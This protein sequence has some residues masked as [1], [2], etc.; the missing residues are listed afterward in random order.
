[1]KPPD[2]A[3]SGHAALT[4]FGRGVEHLLDAAWAGRPGFGPIDRFD[5]GG[6]RVRVAAVLPGLDTTATDLR[7]ELVAAITAAAERAGLTAD[8]RAATALILALHA[9]PQSA[10]AR[11]GRRHSA[12]A[13]ATA[14]ATD[15]GL[16]AAI[17]TYTSACVAASTAVASA[18]AL[19]SRAA[20]GDVGAPARV[21]VAAGYLVESDQFAVFDAARVLALDGQVRPFSRGRKGLLL[22]DGVAAV[23][24]EATGGLRRRGGDPLA[25]LCGWARTGDA[26][27]VCQPR[28]DGAGLARAIETAL[29]RGGVTADQLGYVNAH[30]AGSPQ[31]D[32]A[33]AAALVRAGVTS[34]VSSTKSVHGQALEASALIELIITVEALRHGR[35]PVNAGYLG[36]DDDC[37]LDVVTTPRETTARHAMS[38]NAAFG[39]ANTALLVGAA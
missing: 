7:V 34:P 37:P 8:E 10:R 1:V 20:S 25:W 28:P 26:Y 13:F 2:V 24:L 22:G 3:I 32:R 29:G 17:R 5:V 23:V 11:D 21:I 4:S 9:D 35:L 12:S 38:L 16:G 18:A 30:G 27:H 33:E 39:G 14:V 31:S 6:R 15:A 36:P 19:I